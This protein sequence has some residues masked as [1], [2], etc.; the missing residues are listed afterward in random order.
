MAIETLTILPNLEGRKFGTLALGYD[1]IE[2]IRSE[3]GVFITT[4]STLL[5]IPEKDMTLRLI[6]ER[7]ADLQGRAGAMPVEEVS[8]AIEHF[9]VDADDD[10]I[11]LAMACRA[12]LTETVRQ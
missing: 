9:G 1:R 7:V 11:A 5:G 2:T 3:M 12:R 10:L 4:I 8:A 6:Q